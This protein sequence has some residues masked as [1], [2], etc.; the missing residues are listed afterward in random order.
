MGKHVA[1]KIPGVYTQLQVCIL[2]H[3][4]YSKYSVAYLSFVEVHVSLLL[5]R[6][7]VG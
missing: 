1:N 7:K 3:N 2:P 4:K 6:D 5:Q